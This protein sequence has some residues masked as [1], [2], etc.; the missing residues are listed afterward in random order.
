MFWLLSLNSTV[1]TNEYAVKKG[2]CF[3]PLNFDQIWIESC[4]SYYTGIVE[5]NKLNIAHPAFAKT[6]SPE[7]RLLSYISLKA[8]HIENKINMLIQGSRD[9]KYPEALRLAAIKQAKQLKD[10]L[11]A[12]S[13]DFFGEKIDN[14]AQDRLL[15]IADK[16]SRV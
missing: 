1:K 16:V 4:D 12:I 8:N 3:W 13:N 15:K 5:I 9:P 11:M 7:K 14:M 10:N 6:V 2:W